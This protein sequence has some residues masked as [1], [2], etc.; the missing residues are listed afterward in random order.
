[1]IERPS[2]LEIVEASIE[3]NFLNYTKLEIDLAHVNKDGRSSYTCEDVA[4]IV[5]HLLNDLRLEASDEKSFGEEICSYFVRSGE[6]K[7]KRYK[8]VF[9]VCSDRPES[10]GVITLHRVR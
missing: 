4:E 5:S 9:C 6:F 1:M 7:D 8:L 2:A 3:F 10:I